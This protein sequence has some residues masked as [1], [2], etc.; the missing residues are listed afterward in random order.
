MCEPR[1]HEIAMQLMKELPVSVC[2]V[3]SRQLR[4]GQILFDRVAI[5]ET[6]VATYK[7]TFKNKQPNAHMSVCLK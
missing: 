3:A 5:I 1:V 6:I 7:E 2:P 4:Q